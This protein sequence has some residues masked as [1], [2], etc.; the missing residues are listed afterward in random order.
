ML[1]VYVV[2]HA[3]S[4]KSTIGELIAHTLREH[5]FDAESVPCVPG[6]YRADY[7]PLL[8]LDERLESIKRKPDGEKIVVQEM[9][10]PRNGDFNVIK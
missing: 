3:A 1:K 4:G 7:D 6:E 8:N 9:Q 5:G 2:G 10:A